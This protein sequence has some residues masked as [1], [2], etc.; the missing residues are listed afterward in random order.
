MN[1]KENSNISTI[2]IEIFRAISVPASKYIKSGVTLTD[3]FLNLMKAIVQNLLNNL[4]ESAKE[5]NDD[6]DDESNIFETTQYCLF[7][8]MRIVGNSS[9]ALVIPFTES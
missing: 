9:L 8:Y 1:N 7:S 2:T 4:H 3:Y 5:K 6:D